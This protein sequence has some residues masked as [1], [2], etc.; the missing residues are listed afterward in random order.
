MEAN[1]N[2]NTMVQNLWDAAEMVL[3]GKLEGYRPV[4]FSQILPPAIHPVLLL[5]GLFALIISFSLESPC[6]CTSY[7][8]HHVLSSLS[9]I[10]KIPT[11]LSRT[12][13]MLPSLMKLFWKSSLPPPSAFGPHLHFRTVVC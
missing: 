2:E 12:G 7:S 4:S 8:D 1:E 10:G 13:S 5:H 9:S 6:L 3:R 11:H